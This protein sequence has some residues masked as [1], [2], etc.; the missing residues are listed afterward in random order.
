MWQAILQEHKSSYYSDHLPKAA[1]TGVCKGWLSI[2][3]LHYSSQIPSYTAC[4]NVLHS[5]YT[6]AAQ[7]PG[8]EQ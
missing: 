2:A 8:A 1:H 6:Q 5:S 3:N 4:V 7:V